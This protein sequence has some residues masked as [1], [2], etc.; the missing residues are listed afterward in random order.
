MFRRLIVFISTIAFSSGL[1]LS[2]SKKYDITL[3]GATG[4][5][6]QLAARYLAKEYGSLKVC[7][8][9]RSM[10]KL[11]EIQE[12]FNLNKFDL[13]V[14]DIND[15]ESLD[16][17]TSASKVLMSTAGPFA[18][19]GAPIVDS[20]MRSSTHYVD[21][22]GEPQYVRSLIDRHHEE[23]SIKGTLLFIF[24]FQLT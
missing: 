23:A 3:W 14:A 6:G 8:A 2:M 20:C 11:R 5:T 10:S 19:I 24:A 22:T 18:K 13:A 16:I 21:I 15:S 9:G 1:I 12:N 4:F 7:L 17:L